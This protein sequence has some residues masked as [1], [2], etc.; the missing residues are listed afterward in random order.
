ML[1]GP[2]WKSPLPQN[3]QHRGDLSHRER[4]P[5]AWPRGTAAAAHLC[6][7]VPAF[8]LRSMLGT[9]FPNQ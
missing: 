2:G 4:V 1:E 3:A 6:H 7:P 5:S 9:R 8:R